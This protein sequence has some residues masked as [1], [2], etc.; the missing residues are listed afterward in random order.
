VP[1]I[2]KRLL[3]RRQPILPVKSICQSY[4]R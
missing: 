2:R 3:L 4:N 1:A